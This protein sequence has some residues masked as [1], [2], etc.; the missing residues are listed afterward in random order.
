MQLLST[1]LNNGIIVLG[2]VLDGWTLCE[3]MFM[4]KQDLVMWVFGLAGFC[5]TEVASGVKDLRP[6]Q[7][8]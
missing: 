3:V 2:K 1:L 4:R 5:G 7:V 6:A 8:D